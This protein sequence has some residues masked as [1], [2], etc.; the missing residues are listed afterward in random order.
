M[1]SFPG[2]YPQRWDAVTHLTHKSVACVFLTDVASGLGVHV[3]DP[4]NPGNPCRCAKLYGKL[5]AALYVSVMRKPLT[6]ADEAAYAENKHF[7]MADAR[8]MNQIFLEENA[9]PA[10]QWEKRRLEALEEAEALAARSH[11]VAPWGCKWF[12]D[13]ARNILDAH[14][15]GQT[16]EVFYFE[17][18]VGMGKVTWDELATTDNWA[19]IGL[20]GSQ[21][22]E[23]AY[24]D[25]M[26]IPYVDIDVADF[27]RSCAQ[28]DIDVVDFPA[29]I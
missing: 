4:E 13:W 17:G 5:E 7:K 2:K 22:C 14:N 11:Y 9:Y 18:E 10:D 6:E 8:A 21:K 25:E 23:V 12:V 24:L 16:L 27:E 29:S 28:N 1:G 19:G 15:L 20:G 26:R 3:S